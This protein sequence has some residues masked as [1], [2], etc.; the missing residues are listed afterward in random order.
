MGK[1]TREVKIG[2]VIIGG[3]HPIAVQSMT[4]TYTA[5]VEATCQQIKRLEEA[6]CHIVRVA[7]PD[8]ASAAAISQIKKR[9]AIPLVADIHFDYRLAIKSIE[10]GADKIRI[11]PGNIGSSDRIK[12]V[13]DAAKDRGIPIRIGVNSGSIE[14]EYLDK[15]GRTPEA[16]VESALKNV[17]MLE[18]FG[19]E[20]IVISLKASDVSTTVKSYIM[21][22]QRLDYP[23]HIGITEA[24]TM[25]GGTIKSSVGLGILLW[26]GIGDTMRVSLTAD[27]VEEVKVGHQILKSL[28]LEKKGVE[29]ISCPTCGRCT[30]DIINIA[31]EIEK[32]LQGVQKDIK[33][34]IMGCVVNGPG[35]ARDADIGIAGGRD[36]AVLF[37]RGKVVK[38][39][40]EKDIIQELMKGINEL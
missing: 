23:L 21:V 4:T 39:I 27:P 12:A 19:F 14:K 33:V 2:D 16:L 6:G 30:V 34:A 25:W 29:I 18:D 31:N 9:I 15:Y 7:V 38:K 36:C 35:E 37:K 17:K 20:D 28:G 5:D 11:N 3:G 26:M 24:G 8:E 32:R 22:S 40:A 13:V 10:S 1:K